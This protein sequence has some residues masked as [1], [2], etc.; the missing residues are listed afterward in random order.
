[1][2]GKRLEKDS[3]GTR[4]IPDDVYYGIQT[5]RAVL[6][7]L[8][9]GGDSIGGR[10]LSVVPQ[11]SVSLFSG[12]VALSDGKGNIVLDIPDFNG[13]LRLM[14]VAYTINK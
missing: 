12:L 5:D 4:E 3:I 2:A 6:G 13:E 9:T 10:S 8:R 14:A 11:K 7:E 1:M